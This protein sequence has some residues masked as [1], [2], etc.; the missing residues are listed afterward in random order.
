MGQELSL[1]RELAFA[2]CIEC[3]LSHGCY[4]AST[5]NDEPPSD[6]VWH[7]VYNWLSDEGGFLYYRRKP[8]NGVS[9][10][11]PPVEHM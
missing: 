8:G 5:W 7:F 3:F 10:S 11:E 2:N 1:R 4:V 6:G 9:V